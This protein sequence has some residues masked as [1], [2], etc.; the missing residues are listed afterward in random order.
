MFD[1]KILII[2]IIFL[3]FIAM[4][5]A[6]IFG[7]EEKPIDTIDTIDTIKNKSEDRFVKILDY[8]NNFIMY[9]KETKVEYFVFTNGITVLYDETGKP[10]LYKDEK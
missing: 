10:L 1:S 8:G 4:M 3:T 5:V 2:V 9:D 6:F 7:E